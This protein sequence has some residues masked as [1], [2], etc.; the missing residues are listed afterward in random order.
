VEFKH[1]VNISEGVGTIRVYDS[2]GV[3]YKNGKETGVSGSVFASEM[4]HLKTV[5]NKINIRFNSEGGSVLDG[6]AIFS[7]ILNSE[8][9]TES[10]IDGVAAST[11]GWCAMAA[12]KVNI[13]DYGSLMVHGASGPEDQEIINLANGSIAKMLSNRTGMT[14][15][16]A[17]VLM[18]KETWFK[19]FDSKDRAT[20][21]N[22]K[23][24]DEVISTG[25]KV[26]IAKN[27]TSASLAKIYNKILNP[28]NMSKINTLLKISNEAGDAEQEQAI[29][30][31]NVELGEKTTELETLKN[32]IKELE[33]VANEKIE[34]EKVA[35]KNRAT[36]MANK[37]KAEGKLQE[38]EVAGTIENASKDETSFQFVSNLISKM[39]NGKQA[40]HVFDVKNVKKSDGS[41]EDRSTWTFTDW[42]KKDEKGLGKMQNESPDQFKELYNKEFKK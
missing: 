5:C 29:V 2:I 28:T 24:V 25:K 19:A 20:L 16:E 11:A 17:K 1:I 6:Y 26:K 23:F 34:A 27:E 18:T 21:L 42:S 32:K 13:S 15:D 14:E 33:K 12:N 38:S 41:S 9:D 36:E 10:F 39:G 8:V 7:S 4:A 40:V 35:L 3:T 31:L 22:K 30:K 37:A